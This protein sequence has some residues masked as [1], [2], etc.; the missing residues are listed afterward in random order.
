MISA[1]SIERI[2]E[3]PIHTVVSHY[4]TGLR[5]AGHSWKGKS[6]WTNEKT[7]SFFV[8]PSKNIF[9][10]FSSGRG[11]DAITFVMEM[12][13]LSYPDAIK[14]I[15]D[16]CGERIEYDQLSKEDIDHALD[17]DIL[18]KM[19][20]ATARQYAQQLH[21][22]W[23]KEKAT[24]PAAAEILKRQ[25][26]PEIVLQWQIGYAPGATEGYAPGE[27]QF[28]TKL[29]GATNYKAA[30]EIGLVKN[31]QEKG[32]TYDTFRHRVIYPIHDHLGR[33]A[34]FGGRALKE[35]DYNA[36]YLNSPESKVYKKDQILFGLHYA[37]K[38]IRSCGYAY[39]MEGYTDVISF[40]Q[41]GY[42]CSVGTCG[43]ALTESQCKLLR[44]YTG[45]VVLFYD[46]DKAGQSATVRAIDMLVSQGFEVGVVPMPELEDG[47]KVDPDELV[48]MFQVK[49]VA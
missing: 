27:W 4:V 16:K 38:A 25:F 17:K 2:K 1:S 21:Q 47:R 12:T 42:P 15:A 36:K 10:D 18:F 37:H 8:V 23:M 43:T 26:T 39:L 35:D 30:V 29:I 19:N 49:K 7:G 40:H 32:I 45:K 3:I 6:P 28:L 11:G 22:V 24:H 20:Q 46:G 5:K 33:I 44:R 41:A 31:D 13:G 9:K 34:G 48:R 14:D